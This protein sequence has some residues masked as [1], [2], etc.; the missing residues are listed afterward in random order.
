MK[1]SDN[2]AK[3]SEQVRRA[4]SQVKGNEQATKMSLILPFFA[5]LGYDVYD[6]AEVKPEYV[7]SFAGKSGGQVE[8]VDYAIAINDQIIMIVEAKARDKETT[9]HKIQLKKYFN[10]LLSAKIGVVTNGVEYRFFT[11]LNN[12]NIMDDE[13]FFVFDILGYTENQVENLKL[14]HRDNFDPSVIKSQAEEL[15]YLQ[16]MVQLIENLLR[17]P[18]EEFIRF[19][20]KQLGTISPGFAV[21]KVITSNVIKRFQ[22]IVRKAL[23]TN[24]LSFVAQS[25]DKEMGEEDSTSDEDADVVLE[26]IEL[27]EDPDSKIQTTDEELKAFDKIKAIVS[28]S[29]SYSLEVKHKD[30]LSYFGLNVGKTTWWFIRLYLTNKKKSLVARLPL[31]QVRSLAPGFDVEDVSSSIG[32]TASRVIIHSIDDLDKL[33]NLIL[34]CYET[35]SAQH[36][37]KK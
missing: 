31:D 6:P 22:P 15:I 34:E 33:S 24:L 29:T 20:I 27:S 25:F 16:G 23:K 8:K 13:A 3:V 17:S 7:A 14:F 28:K 12:E 4:E 19:L 26:D 5:A 32:G 11:D 1:F 21:N 37:P 30:V 35:E 2:I 10:A 9:A 36:P 18:S